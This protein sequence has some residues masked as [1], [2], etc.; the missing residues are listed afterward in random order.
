M[1]DPTYYYVQREEAHTNVLNELIM[2]PV[3][4]FQ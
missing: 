1:S 2:M 3:F 4:E